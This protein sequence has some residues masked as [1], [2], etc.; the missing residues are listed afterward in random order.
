MWTSITCHGC[1]SDSDLNLVVPSYQLDIVVSTYFRLLYQVILSGPSPGATLSGPPPGHSLRTFLWSN[2][3]G[4]PPGHSSGQLSAPLPGLTHQP[5]PGPFF[6][7]H[8][9]RPSFRSSLWATHCGFR[10]ALRCLAA[11]P[12]IPDRDTP[13]RPPQSGIQEGGPL[14][15]LPASCRDPPPTP[16]S[17]YPIGRPDHD[18]RGQ[19]QVKGGGS[20]PVGSQSAVIGALADRGGLRS[21]DP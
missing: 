3:S 9:L 20:A 16:Q 14:S 5:V 8:L 17:V 18:P 7:G 6:H 13:S 21:T 12:A 1:S 11:G 19:F 15:P 2:S 10:G 4:P